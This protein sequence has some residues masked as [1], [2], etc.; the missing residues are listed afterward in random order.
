MASSNLEVKFDHGSLQAIRRLTDALN[1]QSKAIEHQN[2]LTI[3][4]HQD[5][6]GKK[7][8]PMKFGDQ[9]MLMRGG[10]YIG[11]PRDIKED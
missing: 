6:M 9:G 7:P 2:Q 5:K 10:E 11:Q 8:E 4:A 3:E 1:R